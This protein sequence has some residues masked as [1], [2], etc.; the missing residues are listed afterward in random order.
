MTKNKINA[1]TKKIITSSIDESLE[2]SMEIQDLIIEKKDNKNILGP[3]L[4]DN[5]K[6]EKDILKLRRIVWAISIFEIEEAKPL[7]RKFIKHENQFL[8]E[9]AILAL[10]I[11]KDEESIDELKKILNDK[12]DLA[13]EEA[14]IAL[15]LMGVKDAIDILIDQLDDED[16]N[17]V[18]A[19]CLA[20]SYLR[21]PK[22]IPPLIK[23]IT[24][25]N[26]YVR[27]YAKKSVFTFGRAALDDLREALKE[28]PFLKKR[29]IRSLIN[30][31]DK[32]DYSE[33][34]QVFEKV[35]FPR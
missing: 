23:K 21:D 13:R 26:K 33:V 35:S 16:I 11:L 1:L 7:L 29:Y 14:A 17:I 30:E 12:N 24:D 5:L 31:I 4:I 19:T 3:I 32:S 25:D 20:L 15:G 18:I 10:G 8:R 6:T 34:H 2:A 27:R 9:E 22:S 28:A